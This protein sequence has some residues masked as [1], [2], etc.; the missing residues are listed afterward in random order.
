MSKPKLPAG[1]NFSPAPPSAPHE[2]SQP[3]DPAVLRQQAA[4]ATMNERPL[5]P[6]V[7]EKS[8]GVSLQPSQAQATTLNE[9]TMAELAKGEAEALDQILGT[10]KPATGP[11]TEDLPPT[12]E[13]GGLE[14]GGAEVHESLEAEFNGPGQVPGNE[15]P[16]RPAESDS[17]SPSRGVPRFQADPNKTIT[18]GWG[19]GG[20]GNEYFALDGNELQALIHSLMADLSKTMSADLRFSLAVVYPQVRVRVHVQVDGIDPSVPLNEQKFELE[21]TRLVDLTALAMDDESTPADALRDLA[22]V[23]KPRKQLVQAG[24]TQIMVDRPHPSL[25]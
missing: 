2:T 4:K 3:L 7:Y 14:A 21:K 15:G 8:V 12:G 17:D 25:N 18:G 13:A 24:A 20:G 10:G 9:V 5:K 23:D 16:R 19:A 6:L 1:G 22:G 11:L